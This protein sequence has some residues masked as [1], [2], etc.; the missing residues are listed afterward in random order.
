MD[1]GVICVEVSRKF[2]KNPQFGKK[3]FLH[4]DE[5]FPK[6]FYRSALTPPP[7]NR[8][9]IIAILP[10][11][12]SKNLHRTFLHDVITSGLN[13]VKIKTHTKCPQSSNPVL[14]RNSILNTNSVPKIRFLLNYRKPFFQKPKYDQPF[15]KK[16]SK[17]I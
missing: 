15:K 17:K 14:N 13:R 3:L 10:E 2:S 9:D 7:K 12:F 6:Y 4:S 16:I 8:P 1:F 5:N 11:V